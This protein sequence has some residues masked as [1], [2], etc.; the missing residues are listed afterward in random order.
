MDKLNNEDIQI[1]YSWYNDPLDVFFESFDT[2]PK[3]A[4]LDEVSYQERSEKAILSIEVLDVEKYIKQNEL[5]EI[6]KRE[7]APS[8]SRWGVSHFRTHQH[9]SYICLIM[10]HFCS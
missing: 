2:N 9:E 5:K 1:G 3:L 7:E 6:T 8:S 10:Y 4:D